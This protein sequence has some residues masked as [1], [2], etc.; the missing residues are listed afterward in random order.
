[1]L[2]CLYFIVFQWNRQQENISSFF[3]GL[4]FSRRRST[5]S[6][7]WRSSIASSAPPRLPRLRNNTENLPLKNIT[8]ELI[9]KC[10]LEYRLYVN[11][12][13]LGN[14]Q[15][16]NSIDDWLVQQPQKLTVGASGC[17][18]CTKF[19]RFYGATSRINN[20]V[21]CCMYERIPWMCE[22]NFLWFIGSSQNMPIEFLKISNS[23]VGY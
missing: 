13:L 7:A 6:E 21:L 16:K 3:N 1:M 5:G 9:D 18:P 11:C 15:L 4:L 17:Q 20:C 22:E 12:I 23:Y 2:V 8:G 10:R 14:W 19:A